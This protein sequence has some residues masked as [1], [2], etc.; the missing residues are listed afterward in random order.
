MILFPQRGERYARSSQRRRDQAICSERGWT[1][2]STSSTNWRSSPARSIGTLS[3]ARSS[4][5][6]ATR[7]GPG[8]RHGLRSGC[9]CSS[10]LTVCPTKCASAGSAVYYP[11]FPISSTSLG[12][13]SSSTSSRMNARLAQWLRTASA[14][15]LAERMR[16]R[17]RV[18]RRSDLKLVAIRSSWLSTIAIVV[19]SSASVAGAL[20]LPCPRDRVHRQRQS[21]RAYEFGVKVSIVITNAR[22]PGGQFVLHARESASRRPYDGHTLRDVIEDTQK[23]TG[24][25]IDRARL[26]RQ[27][28]PRA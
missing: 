27:G 14:K 9:Y 23:L 17:T 11:Y 7:A 28:L 15:A 20:F 8:S 3:T 21:Q 18:G 13:S 2:S 22:V 1:R 12:R 19:S 16:G 25:E 26:R 24:C 10:I 4:R 5:S 6:A